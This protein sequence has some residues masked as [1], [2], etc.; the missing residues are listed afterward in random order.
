M[1][2]LLWGAPFMSAVSVF[3][4]MTLL[5]AVQRK[6]KNAGI[7]DLGWVLCILIT[8]V[9]ACFFSEGDPTRRA[10]VFLMVFF[11]STRLLWHLTRRFLS[12]AG[13]DSR[14]RK[15]REE[16]KEQAN[17]TFLFIFLFQAVTTLL[18][19]VPFWIAS[20]DPRPGLGTLEVAAILLWLISLTG[21]ALA[22]RQLAAFKA[23]KANQGKVCQAGLWNY[24][25]HPNYFFECLIWVS[26]FL[27]ASGSPHGPWAVTGPAL[28]IFFIVKVSGLPPAEEQS[29]RS[30]GELYREYQRT[31][32]PLVPWFK[33]KSS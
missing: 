21:E 5:W 7:V 28:M 26:F 23:D 13:E 9:F 19:S 22:D 29:L 33:K 15:I 17:A 3:S 10:A 8:A 30:K 24:S 1:T 31:T 20:T 11:W 14:Y 27:I 18:L 2:T 32:S 6:T 25:R 12:H 4:L 16:K